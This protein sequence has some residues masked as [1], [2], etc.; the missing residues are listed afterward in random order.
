MLKPMSLDEI[1]AKHP[2]IYRQFHR[3]L[4]HTPNYFG[5]LNE[6]GFLNHCKSI[7]D[8]GGGF[9]ELDLELLKKTECDLGYIEPSEAYSEVFRGELKRA[10]L[11]QRVTEFFQ[12]PLQEYAPKQLYDLVMAIHSWYAFGLDEKA[13]RTA[14]SA[15][16]PGG[17]LLISIVG[18]KNFTRSIMARLGTERPDLNSEHLHQW[19]KQLGIA[20]DYFVWDRKIALSTIFQDDEFTA[21]GK[22][23]LQFHTRT[24]W[25]DVTHEMQEMVRLQ[26]M[27]L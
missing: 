8:I 11:E 5:L 9:G 21:D 20:H 24:A 14:L 19:L 22:G 7:L 27:G 3:I 16:E 26:W 12:G 15:V 1:Y 18:P 6:R 23:F 13:L 4:G 25:N 10:G 17:R 2:Q